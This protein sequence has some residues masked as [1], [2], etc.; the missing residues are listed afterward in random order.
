MDIY[1]A[2]GYDEKSFA[3][4]Q[5]VVSD[6]VGTGN[7]LESIVR[8]GAETLDR[9][10]YVVG[11]LIGMSIEHTRNLMTQWGNQHGAEAHGLHTTPDTRSHE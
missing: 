11:L 7:T 8:K 4:V 9:D 2:A 10:S 5:R 3:E 1:E 6:V